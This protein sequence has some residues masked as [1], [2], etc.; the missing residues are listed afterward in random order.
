M[1]FLFR[2]S[3]ELQLKRLLSLLDRHEG[4][5]PEPRITHSLGKLW[6]ELQPRL[7][8][9]MQQRWVDDT[10]QIASVIRELQQQD[11]DGQEARYPHTKRGEA[12]KNIAGIDLTHFA[13]VASEAVEILIGIENQLEEAFEFTD[14][15]RA[16]WQAEIRTLLASQIC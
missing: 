6:G 10:T 7:G 2:H 15:Q 12:F 4:E 3:I 8:H 13:E 1:A 16:D 14:E 5:P 11:P 9:Y